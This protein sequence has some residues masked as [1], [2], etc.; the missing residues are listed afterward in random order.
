MPDESLD[1]KLSVTIIATGFK[2]REEIGNE[3][4]KKNRSQKTIRVLG[5]DE[6]ADVPKANQ[7]KTPQEPE[8]IRAGAD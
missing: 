7:K 8:S 3:I 4:E 1:E 6:P 5:V 2:T